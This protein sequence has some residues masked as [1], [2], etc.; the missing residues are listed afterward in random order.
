M[1]KS[2]RASTRKANNRRLKENVFG[3][4]EEA[5][6]QR[7]AAKLLEIASQP[8]PVPEKEMKDTPVEDEVEQ[9]TSDEHKAD[10]A[11][12]IDTTAKSTKPKKGKAIKRRGKKSNIVFPKFGDRKTIKKKR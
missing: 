12:D 7:L 4:V 6:Q 11:M 5:R 10:T 1:A 8:K 3:P 9:K 2:S